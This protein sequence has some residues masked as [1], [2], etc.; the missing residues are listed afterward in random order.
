VKLPAWPDLAIWLG[1]VLAI[2]VVYAQTGQFEFS[3]YDDPEYLSSHVQ[4]GLTLAGI[5]WA[6]TAIVSANWGPVTLLSHMLDCQLFGMDSGAHHLVN[7]LFHALAAILLFV[8]L[9]RAS[10]AYWPSAFVAFVF[11]VHPLHVESVAWVAER[12]DVL[13]AFFWFVALYAYI[14][15]TERESV[16]GYLLVAI[17]VCLGLMSKPMMVTFPFALLLFDAWPLRRVRFPKALIE[18]LPLITLSAAASAVTWF[19][20]TGAIQ[21]GIPLPF[22]LRNAAFSY[23]AYIRQMFWPS[24]LVVFYPYRNVKVWEAVAA[25]GVI[26]GVSALLIAVRRNRPYLLIG[27]LWYLGTLVPAIGLVQVG[28]QAMADRYTYIPAIGISVM[29][30]WSAADLITRHPRLKPAIAT[31]AVLS[32]GLSIALAR[33]QTSYWMNSETL[34]RHALDVDKDNYVARLNLGTY[35]GRNGRALEAIPLFEEV[36]R[37]IPGDA[38]V[39]NSLAILLA[40]QPGRLEEAIAHFKSA[41]RL[42]PDYYEAQY[43]LGTAL[44]QVPGRESEALAHF[45]AAQRIQPSLAVAQIIDRLRKKSVH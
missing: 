38:N 19:A 9:K 33:K 29:L 45:E 14:R 11:A 31:L 39:H 6:F 21:E 28:G 37:Y 20:Q 43:N 27:W 4:P 24:G 10:G 32:C 23:I 25:A 2:L 12:K 40:D 36:V 42:D 7:V 18:K 15:Y 41:V 22:R 3:S 26:A 35:L 30:A 1:L 16:R 8:C 44:S 34:F 5:K 17:P 13:F